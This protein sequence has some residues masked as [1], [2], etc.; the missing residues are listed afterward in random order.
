MCMYYLGGEYN[1]RSTFLL[2]SSNPQGKMDGDIINL[3]ISQSEV[4]NFIQLDETM[5][6]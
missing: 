2:K 1:N 4:K 3:M 6:P 5:K